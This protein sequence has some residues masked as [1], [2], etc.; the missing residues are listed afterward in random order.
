MCRTHSLMVFCVLASCVMLWQQIAAADETKTAKAVAPLNTE[1]F[2]TSFEGAWFVDKQLKTKYEAAKTRLEELENE[3][4]SGKLERENGEIAISDARLELQN[5]R[6]EIDE[7]KTLVSAFDIKTKTVEQKIESGPERLLIVTADKIKIVGWHEPHAK[8]VLVKKVLSSG[9]AVDDHLA[10]IEVTHEHRIAPEL[11]GKTAEEYAADKTAYANNAD[12]KLRTEEELAA[13]TRWTEEIATSK[14]HYSV[15]QGKQ[16]DL[17]TVK[18]LTHQEG[19][20]QASYDI[21]SPNGNGQAG[22]RWRRN[23]E[24]TLFVP[25]CTALLLQG[26]EVGTDIA[27]VDGQLILT[28]AGSRN[29]D[30]AGTFNISEHRGTITLLNVPI[31]S[32]K[33][34]LGDVVIEST[35]SLSGPADLSGHK[36]RYGSDES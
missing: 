5:V 23:A 30:Y 10:G 28:S 15:F 1:V 29:R 4:R 24:L 14:R 13:N 11:V 20:R 16:A 9:E 17:L 33:H 36:L 6:Q 2:E 3:I 19:N 7:Q 27:G 21:R 25:A 31:D 35:G 18:G 32:V 34:V 26:C 22:S 8:L 12:G